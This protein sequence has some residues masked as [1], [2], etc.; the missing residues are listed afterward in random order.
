MVFAKFILLNTCDV[1]IS[2]SFTF[3]SLEPPLSTYVLLR[4]LYY[5]VSFF[6]LCHTVLGSNPG[7]G[8]KFVICRLN[9]VL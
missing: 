8:I 1:F 2:F 5:V 4:T 6:L 9:W 3:H 7:G